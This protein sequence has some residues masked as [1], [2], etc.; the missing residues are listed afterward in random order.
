MSKNTIWV[1]KVRLVELPI[2]DCTFLIIIKIKI[3]A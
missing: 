1:I 2:I 3:K